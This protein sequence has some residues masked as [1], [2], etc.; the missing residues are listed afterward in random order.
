MSQR[1]NT[2]RM[3]LTKPALTNPAASVT[4]SAASCLLW[5]VTSINFIFH[6]SVYV[7]ELLE[8]NVWVLFS[9]CSIKT[10]YIMCFGLC[11]VLVRGEFDS[12]NAVDYKRTIIHSLATS[13]H[14]CSVLAL[15]GTALTCLSKVELEPP[16]SQKIRQDASYQATAH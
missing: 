12:N 10:D 1:Q 7:S 16:P 9:Q 3:K 2:R 5:A 15:Y 4:D 13:L 11:K 6:C 8:L 14:C